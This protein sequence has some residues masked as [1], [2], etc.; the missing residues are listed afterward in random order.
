[1]MPSLEPQPEPP[2]L[3]EPSSYEKLIEI[4]HFMVDTGEVDTARQLIA[5][6]PIDKLEAILKVASDDDYV[7]L[8]MLL[9]PIPGPIYD[10]DFEMPDKP[11]VAEVIRRVEHDR[12][13][14]QDV[15]DRV[16][17]D[18]GM[19]H[20]EMLGKSTSFDPQKD[21]EFYSSRVSDEVRTIAA[22]VSSAK[23]NFHAKMM[24]VQNRDDAQRVEDAALYWHECAIDNYYDATGGDLT[25][26]EALYMLITGYTVTRI[27]INIKGRGYPF[28]EALIDPQNVYPFWD[29]KGL[30]RVSVRYRD[31]V[32]RV[33]TEYEHNGKSVRN[34]ILNTK[35]HVAN[36]GRGKPQ[37]YRLTDTCEVTVYHDR[38]WYCVLVDGIPIIGP[39]EHKYGC[40]PY[41]I[42]G[43][44]LGEPPGMVG[45]S[46]R[47]LDDGRQFYEK[48]HVGDAQNR[49]KYKNVS[50][51]HFRKKPHGQREVILSKL[52]TI[53]QNA[54]KPAWA[55]YQDDLADD[56]PIISLDPNNINT[57]S[58]HE[59][60][61]PLFA[62]VD[63]RVWGPLF[64]AMTQDEVTNALPPSLLG[65]FQSANESGNALEGSYEAGKDKLVTFIRAAQNHQ[66][67]KASL[68]LKLFR[69]WGEIIQNEN[70]E[71]ATQQVPHTLE[72]QRAYH[73]PSHFVI[74]P[75]T[76]ERVGHRVHAD[77]VHLRMQNLGPL[78]N[79]GRMWVDMDAM[80]KRELMEL[81]GVRD[82]DAVIAERN[83]EKAQE[84]EVL[85]RAMMLKE[86][87]IRDPEAYEI[88]RELMQYEHAKATQGPSQ[89]G[90]PSGP[91]P[92]GGVD[93]S[94]LGLGAEGLTG[95]PPMGNPL[96]LG[97]GAMQSAGGDLS[98]LPPS[99]GGLI[100][101]P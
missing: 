53:L 7:F 95:R 3:T 78:G 37:N 76:I 61:E 14:W 79:A 15:I 20:M 2:D 59:K 99:Q 100:G 51:F 9:P 56:T 10:P 84:D 60:L 28:K 80:S 63:H 26:D 49:M 32:E 62:Q 55:L 50:W 70:G 22:M 33:I 16:Y 52:Y 101:G 85:S 93:M 39:V 31:S 35:N 71:Y 92:M 72:R 69:D 48:K 87:R 65:I 30:A 98:L 86:L 44:M 6:T 24:T 68:K 58:Q 29:G 25:Y 89:P 73:L 43:S 74:T 94:A 19:Y 34:K 90:M 46:P 82:P 36:N 41:V 54:D 40:V 67:A 88:Y 64:S 18:Q 11:D 91:G 5:F 42:T 77:L 57:L 81:R 66:G 97:P 96:P 17:E 21:Q 38:W 47:T 75:H 45:S 83:Y 1:M 27:G 23:P 8:S 13:Q 4:L 12:E